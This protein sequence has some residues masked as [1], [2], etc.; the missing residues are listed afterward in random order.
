MG[1][2]D[3]RTAGTARRAGGPVDLSI[4]VPQ[5]LGV[6]GTQV[7][8]KQGLGLS[9]TANTR[10]CG[11]LDNTMGSITRWAVCHWSRQNIRE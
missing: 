5:V 1:P 11:G 10:K 9:G 8:G 6:V 4:R 3:S 7:V 2:G